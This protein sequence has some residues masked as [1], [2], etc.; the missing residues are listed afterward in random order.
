MDIAIGSEVLAV[1][2]AMVQLCRE[3]KQRESMAPMHGVAMDEPFT[4]RGDK[5]KA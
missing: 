3:A 1:V 5:E 4:N 2:S